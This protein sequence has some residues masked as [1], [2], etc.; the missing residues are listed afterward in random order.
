LSVPDV[1][2]LAVGTRPDCFTDDT[3]GYLEDLSKRTYLSIE[4]GLQSTHDITLERLNRGHTF[5]DFCN[6]AEKLNRMGIE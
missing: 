5:L 3:F 2:G 1:V 4:L 6:A